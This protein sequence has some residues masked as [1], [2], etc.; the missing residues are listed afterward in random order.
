MET[1]I[2]L[3]QS[4]DFGEIINDCIAFIKQNWKGLLRTYFVFCG[5]F[6][7]G[8]ILFSILQQL[9]MINMY[10]AISAGDF[11]ASRSV[12][13]FEYIMVLIFSFLNIVSIILSTLC[14]IA[15]YN[16][17]GKQ[18]PTIKEVWGYYKYYFWRVVWHSLLLIIIIII[19]TIVFMIPT[20]IMETSGSA[21]A[22]GIT[23]IICVVIPWVYFFTILS[24]FFPIVIIENGGFG[25]A[26][27]KCFRLIKGRWWST[28]GVLFVIG[29]VV[30]AG[31][32]LVSLPFYIAS[33]GIMTF[34]AYN[35]S[36]VL[37]IFYSVALGLVQVLNILPMTGV[38]VTY[39]SYAEDKESLGLLER[40]DTLG[41]TDE[42]TDN[43]NEEY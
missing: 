24:L 42:I 13:G 5:F 40:I 31:F 41:K 33:G 19:G 8:N 39:F 23:T 16:E 35:I 28:F 34:M 38:A 21:A 10:R 36:P 17:R 30:Y 7:A 4:R 27:G 1:K 9:K 22:V 25:Y 6:I 20:F 12:F 15:L 3:K 18:A 32:I 2:E 26:F 11:E 29:I 14:Y 43:A 37:A